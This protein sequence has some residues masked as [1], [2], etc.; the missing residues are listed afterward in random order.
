MENAIE[1]RNVEKRFNGFEINDFS[2]EVK[3]GFIT[4]LIGG[5]GVGKSTTLKMI[6]NLL[7]PDRG[8][9]KVFGL[10]YSDHEKEIKERIG[11][12]FDENVFYE[13]L[14]LHEMKKI[15]KWSYSRWDD[16][17]FDQYVTMFQLPLKKKL[18]TF[19]KGMLMKASLAVAF[20]H[21]AELILM[22]EP[23]AGLDP[24]F[25]RELLDI[26]H[27]VMEEGEKTILY[28]TH[29]TTDLESA[30]DYITFIH[31]GRHIFTKP[32]YKIEEDYALI[33]GGL[34]LLDADTEREFVSLK[35]TKFGFE[36]LTADRGKAEDLFGGHALIE[37]PTLEDIMYYTKKGD[38]FHASVNS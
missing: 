28:S 12:V 27:S 29:I 36:A 37:A 2:L 13:Q 31:D 18:K 8:E 5:N 14:T 24:I 22:D 20:S 6:L 21:H 3:K 4:G 17:V 34:E 38:R 35:K 9:L 26:L 23:T 19:S 25:R 15:A 1:L 7:E 16:N 32:Y 10:N 33:K 11:F 30:A